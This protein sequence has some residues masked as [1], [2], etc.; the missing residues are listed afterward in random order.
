MLYEWVLV[1]VLAP[2][3][4]PNPNVEVIDRYRTKQECVKAQGN[5]KNYICLPMDYN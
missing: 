2:G 4:V 5:R 3:P 1:L